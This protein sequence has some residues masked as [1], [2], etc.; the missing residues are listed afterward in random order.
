MD[1]D[2]HWLVEFFAPLLH[3]LE[4]SS[5]LQKRTSPEGSWTDGKIE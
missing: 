2:N 1:D 5:S 4:T 3:A